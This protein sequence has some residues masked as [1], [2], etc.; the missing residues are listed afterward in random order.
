MNNKKLVYLGVIFIILLAVFFVSRISDKTVR[1]TELLLPIDTSKVSQ[2]RIVS[3][4]NGEIVFAKENEL[5][6]IK[7]PLDFPAELRNVQKM[8]EKLLEMKIESIVSTRKASQAEYETSDSAAVYAEF[9]A[10]DKLLGA[11]YMGK[12]AGT[13]RHTY[14]RRPKSDETL[15]VKGN[16]EYF[17]DRKL[18]DWRNKMILE[19]NPEGIESFKIIYPDHDFSVSRRDT[20]WYVKEDKK[21]F[22]VSRKLVDPQLNYISR[23]RAGDFFDSEEGELAPDFSKPACRIEITFSGGQQE[24]LNLLPEDKQE[25][26]YYVKKDS[27]S[28]IYLIYTGT[29]T[30]LMKDV[31]DFRE[32]ALDKR[33]GS[34]PEPHK[35]ND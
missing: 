33:P 31:G 27:D 24:G 4:E 35:M 8:L 18:K 28:T 9:K 23:L 11:F 20:L 12:F 6:R 7:Q 1:K 5:W 25:K 17:F 29:A 21:E 30:A 32:K 13:R 2:I 34:P 14:F 10:G 19:L 22:E 26:R 15:M 3:P 16:Y